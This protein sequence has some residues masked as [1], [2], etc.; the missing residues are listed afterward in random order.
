M[1]VP[2][3]HPLDPFGS[4]GDRAV[5][6]LWFEPSPVP[7]A[8][9]APRPERAH[10]AGSL[11]AVAMVAALSGAAAGVGAVTVLGTHEITIAT[12]PEGPSALAALSLASAAPTPATS[13]APATTTS[14]PA[15]TTAG[16]L[17][18]AQIAAAVGPSVVTIDVQG[19]TAAGRTPSG[20]PGSPV[21]EGSGSGVILTSDGW[22]LTNRHVVT[23][24]TTLNVVLA[25]GRQFPATV[26]GVD[27]YTDF[28]IIKVNATNLPAVTLGDSSATQVGDGVYVIGNPLGQF[29]DSVTGGLVSGLDR[30]ISVTSDTGQGSSNLDH[31]IQTDAAINPGNSGGALVNDVGQVIG[32]ATATSGNAQSIGFALPIN[33][34]KPVI[35]QVEAGQAVSRPWLGIRYLALDAQ[36][37]KQNNLD[38]DNGAW[39]NSDGAT[40]SPVTSGGPADKAGLKANDIITAINGQSIDAAHPL[41]LVVLGYAPGDQIALT[42]DRSGSTIQLTLTLGTRPSTL[43]SAEALA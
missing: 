29:P 38:V 40:G 30:S 21:I 37:A 11:V 12:A 27:T 33:L 10:R 42:V 19:T 35:N 36:V 15:I 1:D 9:I 5:P 32:I 7:F 14:A 4:T 18:A 24:A 25:D 2:D 16:S 39:I 28:A 8:P 20:S 22:I 6:P 31:L 34:A 3:P 43:G 23:N 13:S 41:D 26:K 17:S